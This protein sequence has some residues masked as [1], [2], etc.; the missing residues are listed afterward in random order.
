MFASFSQGNPSNDKNLQIQKDQKSKIISMADEVYFPLD[1][2]KFGRVGAVLDKF[3]ID[4]QNQKKAIIGL[5]EGWE[6]NGIVEKISKIEKS[7]LIAV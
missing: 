2:N 3:K 1:Q 4:K 7:I 6:S 5:E